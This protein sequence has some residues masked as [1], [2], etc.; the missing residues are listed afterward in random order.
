MSFKY[1][2]CTR[3]LIDIDDLIEKWNES[4][5]VVN[6]LCHVLTQGEYALI[7]FI[8]NEGLK[9]IRGQE[10]DIEE[11]DDDPF[12]KPNPDYGIENPILDEDP[13]AT[14]VK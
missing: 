3:E 10:P 4:P 2:V 12:G 13:F 9:D 6:P 5:D 8:V 1:P 14:P 11:P 7:N